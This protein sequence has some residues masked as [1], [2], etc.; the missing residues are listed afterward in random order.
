LDDINRLDEPLP[1]IHH[2]LWQRLVVR[3]RAVADGRDGTIC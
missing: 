1:A 3:R 2:L